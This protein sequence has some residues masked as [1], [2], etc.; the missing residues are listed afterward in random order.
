LSQRN[1]FILKASVLLYRIAMIGY[2]NGVRIAALFNTKAA[3]WFEG[4][5]QQWPDIEA[6]NEQK[7][8]VW[9]HCAS[10]GEFEQGRPVIEGIRRLYPHIPIVLTFYSPSGFEIRKN[11]PLVDHVFYL[12][13]DTPRKAYFFIKKINPC[14]AVFVKYEFWYFHLKALNVRKT[15]TLLI[16]SLFR[17]NQV[18][19]KWHGV[20]FRSMLDCFSQIFVQHQDSLEL[21]VRHHYLNVQVSGDSRIDNVLYRAKSPAVMPLVQDFVGNSPVLVAGSTWPA[22]EN[23]LFDY[24]ESG[25]IDHW[26]IL[27]APHDLHANHLSDI[28]K[29]A[30]KIEVVR[31]SALSKD[32]INTARVLLIDSMGLLFDLYQLGDIAYI[33]GGFGKSI[34]NTLEPAAFGLPVIFGPRYHKFEEAKAFIKTGGGFTVR[35]REELASVMGALIDPNQRKAAAAA[36]SRWMQENKGGSAVILQYIQTILS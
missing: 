36:V 34:H 7:Q 6:L 35:S 21:L 2:I 12:P 17:P 26:K 19:F 32:G 25:G 29:R 8:R 23:L 4:R 15:P 20:F 16:S 14:L 31:L 30:G 27:L 3:L 18:F 13:V 24:L 11:Y 5:K 22:D 28:E 9:F 1:A 33:G 10:L